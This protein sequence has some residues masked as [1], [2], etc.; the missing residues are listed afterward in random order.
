M[1]D[2]QHE[3]DA[4]IAAIESDG[5]SRFLDD[6]DRLGCAEAASDQSCHRANLG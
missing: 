5:L 2:F 6:A 1:T 4:L 3:L